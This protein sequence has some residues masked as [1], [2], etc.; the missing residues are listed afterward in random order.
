MVLPRYAVIGR[1]AVAQAYRV[2]RERLVIETYPED[3]ESWSECISCVEG[4]WLPWTGCDDPTLDMIN[5]VS[6]DYSIRNSPEDRPEYCYYSGLIFE[7]FSGKEFDASL[8]KNA[9]INFWHLL[10]PE[11]MSGFCGI[12]LQ[13][14]E[15]NRVTRDFGT[16]PGTWESKSWGVG[17]DVP[18]WEESP[19]NTAPFDWSRI[20]RVMVWCG[21]TGKTDIWGV[22]K[23]GLFWID[24]IYFTYQLVMPVLR[25]NSTPTGKHYTINDVSGY[26]P[27]R[28]TLDPDVSYTVCMDPEGFLRWEDGTT[29]P[30]RTI[31]LKEG[32]E[33]TIT[34]YYVEAPL[35]P[36]VVWL[37]A[38]LPGL[39][40]AILIIE[41]QLK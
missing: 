6:G 30:C 2:L 17:P 25:I 24:R 16:S 39:V 9:T 34:A 1:P 36:E 28:Y 41:S 4:Q 14:T 21:E 23:G 18:D 22:P 3:P 29:D 12:V 37:L 35:P 11:Y 19:F 32:E 20:K 38:L 8:N 40:G 27:A 7:L 33:K 31:S 13:D 26:T 10:E 15:G 5:K